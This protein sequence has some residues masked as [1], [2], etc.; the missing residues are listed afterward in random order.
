MTDIVYYHY[1][2]SDGNYMGGVDNKAY[3]DPSWIEI[4]VEPPHGLARY[5]NGAWDMST[6][7]RLERDNI[8]ATVVDPLVSNPLRWAG[9]TAVKQTEW[10]QY[11]ND[12][13]GIPQQAG[14]PNTITW[15][16]EP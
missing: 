1:I 13:L 16:T 12:L 2:D 11:R 8:L 9:L 7:H 10:S 5:V 4:L 14:F 6:P 3:A 15:P